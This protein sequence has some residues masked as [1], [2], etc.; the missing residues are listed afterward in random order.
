MKREGMKMFNHRLNSMQ[1]MKAVRIHTYGGPE[2]LRFEEAPRPQAAAGELLI[3]VHAA[4]V[5][6]IDWKIREGRY[7]ERITYLL[8]LIPGWDL[9]GVVEAIGP[10]ATKFQKGRRSVCPPGH[11]SRW[12]R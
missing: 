6:P 5:D 7:K 9:S 11:R 12:L 4:G 1:T 3:H 2:V 10:D 8:P